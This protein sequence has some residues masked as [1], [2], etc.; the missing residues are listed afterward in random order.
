MFAANNRAILILATVTLATVSLMLV[1]LLATRTEINLASIKPLGFLLS[2]QFLLVVYCRLRRLKGLQPIVETIF[3]FIALNF[4]LLPISYAG[5][6]FNL[7]IADGWLSAMDHAI[8]FH[9]RPFIVSIDNRPLL[10]GLLFGAY[11]SFGPQLFLIPAYFALAGGVNRACAMVSAYA[12]IVIVSSVISIWFPSE[13][14]FHFYG[15]HQSDLKNINIHFGVAYLSEFGAVRTQPVF[16]MGLDRIQGLLTFPSVHVAGAVLCTWAAWGSRYLWAPVALLNMAMAV[17]T[18]SHGG[19]FAID[20]VAGV[21]VALACIFL[22]RL[23]F[24]DADAGATRA[25]EARFWREIFQA[26]WRSR[27]ASAVPYSAK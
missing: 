18:I 15:L 27:N 25:A 13:G 9:W 10:A 1:V 17:S 14:A 26:K 23:S 20:V 2:V 4:G 8:G 19:H 12:A 22:S 16:E 11:T 21:F 6:R 7:P 3:L 24:Q 5:M